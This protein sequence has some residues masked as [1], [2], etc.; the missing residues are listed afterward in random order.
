MDVDLPT[1]PGG[2]GSPLPDRIRH[3][4]PIFA[5]RA[6]INSC[7]LGALSDAVAD[8]YARYLRDWRDVGSPWQLWSPKAGEARDAF[9]RL[10]GA[11]PDE[12]AVTT[13]VSAG[14]SSVA[15]GLDLTERPRIVTTD[16]E[17]PATAQVWH[18]QELRGAEVVHARADGN[19]IPLE[20]FDELVDEQTK[21]V[22][23]TS[24][25]YRNGARIDVEGVVR[26]AHE[27]GAL[28]FLDA[29][30]ALGTYPID[31]TELGVDFL[32]AG[33]LKYLLGSPGLAF[34]FCRRDVLAEVVPTVTGWHADRDISEWD[35][36]DYSPAPTAAR[37]QAGTQPIPSLYAGI[38][39]LG[40]IEEI[41]VGAIRE[42]VLDLHRPLL[43]GLDELG[44]AVVTPRE[45][46]RRGALVCVRSR[47][48]SALVAALGDEGIDVSERDGCLRV[49]PHAYNNA[50]DIARLL[51][52]LRAHRDLLE[53]GDAY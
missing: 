12:V 40:L 28:V 5:S 3:R 49:S 9:A 4:F 19:E 52:S 46:E 15:S 51:E 17:F 47:N 42:H 50:D 1:Q 48:V 37:F 43:D 45:P 14:V 30:Q 21:V 7:S 36:Y 6:Y 16:F 2:L 20:C 24:V 26:I 44:A 22:S 34:L 38:A 23:L 35:I 27:R 8:S 13:S 39:A 25:C 11:Q 33:A 41:G 29:Y 32:A 18:A 53:T 31:V 10:I